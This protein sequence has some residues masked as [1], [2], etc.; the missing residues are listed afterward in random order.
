MRE[1]GTLLLSVVLIGGLAVG[2]YWLAQQAR[3]SDIVTRKVG[4]DIDYTATDIT[5]TRMDDTGRAQYVIDAA[6]LV[7]YVDDD[8]GELTQPHMVGAKLDRPEMRVRADL[9][10]TVGEGEEIRL[11]GN[12]V[13]IRQPWRAAPEMVA[14]GPYML[15]YPEREVL[16]SDQPIEVTRGGSR[17][18]AN[19]M[20]Y[21]NA[22][23]KLNLDGGPS[24][25][26]REVIEA[27]TAHKG[28][29]T[30]SAAT[31]TK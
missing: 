4:H 17:V 1:R 10:K 3:L 28:A 14:K 20:Q 9:G 8:T 24:G 6:A 27:R 2:S 15:A 7:H 23:R 13:M 16:S 12:V 11:F 21:D 22:D 18:N 31:P 30:V 26:V 19:G 29:A 25:R 5:L